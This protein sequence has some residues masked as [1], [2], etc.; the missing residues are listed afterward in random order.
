MGSTRGTQSGINAEVHSR[1]KDGLAIVSTNYAAG[2]R[3]STSTY[4]SKGGIRGAFPRMVHTGLWW[5]CEECMVQQYGFGCVRQGGGGGFHFVALSAH[6]ADE[7]FASLP[8]I[9]REP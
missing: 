3:W 4:Q 5:G 7:V 9:H 1:D 6:V 8:L 2:W